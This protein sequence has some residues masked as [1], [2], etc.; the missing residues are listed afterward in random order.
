MHGRKR[1]ETK[2]LQRDAKVAAKLAQKAVAWH[3][4]QAELLKRR[5]ETDN[6]NDPATTLELIQKAV[7]VNPDPLW[8]WNF[9]ADLLQAHSL[10][11]WQ[12]EQSVTQQALQANP[13]SY[14]AWHFRKWCLQQHLIASN[15]DSNSDKNDILEQ[16]IQ[17]TALFFQRDE[18]NFHCWSYR[19]FVVSCCLWNS[20]N[21]D[22]GGGAT[23][24][25]PLGEWKIGDGDSN[26][27]MG[28]QLMAPCQTNETTE[29]ERTTNADAVSFII[30]KEWVFTEEKIRDNF[31]NFSA[32][33][34]RS[35]LLPLLLDLG[36]QSLETLISNEFDMV[37]NA[38]FTEPD[39]QTAW[40]YQRFLLD[41]ISTATNDEQ[42]DFVDRVLQSHIDQL[43]ELKEEY[44]SG[45]WVLTGFLQCLQSSKGSNA[46]ECRSVIEQLLDID[47]DRKERY[48]SLSRK[49]ELEDARSEP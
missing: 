42:N 17:L 4:L 46:T 45:K 38:V 49:L 14:G 5:N 9:R 30:E 47:P 11:D 37:L 31:S 18:R 10:M 36:K 34:C 24:P 12:K 2:A 15:N 48:R 21:T 3:Q 43:R 32:F 35:K 41:F 19:R 44:P 22:D 8:L 16:E 40:W 7:T 26:L 29:S 13:K 20:G 23:P 33:H 39:D 28:A 25:P 27:W 6:K 1:N